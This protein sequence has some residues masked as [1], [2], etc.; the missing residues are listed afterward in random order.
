M[1]R[2]KPTGTHRSDS[3]NLGSIGHELETR[4][5]KPERRGSAAPVDKARGPS[6]E[7]LKMGSVALSRRNGRKCRDDARIA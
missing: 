7:F 5:S 2:D 1:F 4:P 6:P 3:L